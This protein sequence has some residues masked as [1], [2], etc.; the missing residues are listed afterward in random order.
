MTKE[1][2]LSKG[3]ELAAAFTSQVFTPEGSI[4]LGHVADDQNLVTL[5]S[6]PEAG[7]YF[8]HSVSDAKC[9]T[10]GDRPQDVNSIR[11]N[12]LSDDGAPCAIY[13][14]SLTKGPALSSA[15]K[16]GLLGTYKN[17]KDKLEGKFINVKKIRYEKD[18]DGRKSVVE[19]SYV[20]ED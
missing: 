15:A 2:L 11:W 19:L 18:A 7:R 9:R 5:G 6:I 17:S 4:D 14:G 20:I 13:N 8:V 1:E 3:A 12:L 16:A 10:K